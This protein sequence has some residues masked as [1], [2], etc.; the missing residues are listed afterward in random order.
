M[1]YQ[2]LYIS[3]AFESPAHLPFVIL[4]TGEIKSLFPKSFGGFQIS[5]GKIRLREQK[6]CPANPKGF[7]Q[8]LKYRQAFREELNSFWILVITHG[9]SHFHQGSA[10]KLSVTKL[11]RKG[12]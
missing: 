12:Q 5:I 9:Q 7:V 2:P 10:D 1:P 11:P 3:Q 4:F 8:L 6:G